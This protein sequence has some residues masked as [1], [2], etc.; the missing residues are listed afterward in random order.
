MAAHI[1]KHSKIHFISITPDYIYFEGK[2]IYM[3]EM[4]RKKQ[5]TPFNM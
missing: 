2:L 3:S 4:W 1:H 5:K